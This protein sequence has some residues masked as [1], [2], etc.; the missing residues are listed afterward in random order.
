MTNTLAQNPL[1]WST[2][3]AGLLVLYILSSVMGAIRKVG[4]LEWVIVVNFIPTGIGW[5]PPWSWPSRPDLR[6]PPAAFQPAP[7]L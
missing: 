5:W 7:K 4:G 1:F 3:I 2:L 6:E